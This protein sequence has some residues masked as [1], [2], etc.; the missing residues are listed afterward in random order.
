MHNALRGG[1]FFWSHMSLL[2]Y[3]HIVP[4]IVVME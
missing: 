3:K 1:N 4:L 2:S